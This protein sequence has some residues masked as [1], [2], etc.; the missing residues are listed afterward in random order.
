M[1][2]RASESGFSLLEVL[3]ATTVFALAVAGLADVCA[4]AARANTSARDSTLA[5]LLA[6]QKMEQLRSLMWG[7]DTAGRPLS[8]TTTDVSVTPERPSAG[9]GLSPS[10]PGALAQNVAGY[11]DFLDAAGRPLGGGTEPPASAQFARRW[12]VQ[13]LPANLN[14]LVLQVVVTRA[15]HGGA[16]HEAARVVSV[17]GRKAL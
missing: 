6:A 3:V 17:K 14:T 7:F 10:P 15:V 13:P 12:S 16:M 1:K 8:D 4:V 5:S 9:V 11:C 2:Q